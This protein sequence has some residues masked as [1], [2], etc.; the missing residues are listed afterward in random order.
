MSPKVIVVLPTYNEREN[1]TRIA[2]RFGV[3]PESLA[4]RNEL[5]YKGR[6][7]HAGLRLVVPDAWTLDGEAASLPADCA[8]AGRVV[9]VVRAGHTLNAIARAWGVDP[10]TLVELNRLTQGGHW[11]RIG[12]LLVIREAID[13]P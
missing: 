1:I 7:I 9:H 4:I 10:A 2:R 8:D 3:H 11:L 13:T 5:P 6:L 12:Q